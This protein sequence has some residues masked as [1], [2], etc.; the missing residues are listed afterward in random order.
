[1]DGESLLKIDQTKLK[2]LILSTYE[3]FQ[4]QTMQADFE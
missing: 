3:I 1:M 4:S 2:G